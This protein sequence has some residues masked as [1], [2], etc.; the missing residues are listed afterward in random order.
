MS[1]R[2]TVGALIEAHLKASRNASAGTTN[3]AASMLRYLAASTPKAP[4]DGVL[5][6]AMAVVKARQALERIRDWGAGVQPDER[7]T[8]RTVA[9]DALAEIAALE[10]PESAQP[11]GD[12][13]QLKAPPLALAEE[14]KRL[15]RDLFNLTDEAEDMAH[16]SRAID[17]LAALA[18]SLPPQVEPAEMTERDQL[19][20]ARWHSKLGE[21]ADAY[22]ETGRTHPAR[23]K[24]RADLMMHALDCATGWR[25]RSFLAAQR[26]QVEPQ[27]PAEAAAFFLEWAD[28]WSEFRSADDMPNK[29]DDQPH[30]VTPL[31]GAAVHTK[32]S[33]PP[34]GQP[35]T[36]WPPGMLQDDSRELSRALA[37]K[38]DARMHAREAAESARTEYRMLVQLPDGTYVR[39]TRAELK[40]DDMVVFDGPDAFAD[41]DAAGAKLN[42]EID[43]AGGLD[44]WRA[45]RLKAAP[46]A[47]QGEPTPTAPP[48]MALVPLRLTREMDRVMQE[49]DWQWS[50][51]LAAAGTVTEEDCEIAAQ[52][53]QGESAGADALDAARCRRERDKSERRAIAFGDIVAQHVMAMR[54]AV[55]A[56]QREGADAGM[57]WI[58]NTLRGPGHLPNDEDIAFGAQALFDREMAEHDAFRAAHPGPSFAPPGSVQAAGED[59]LPLAEYHEDHGCAVWWTWQDGEWLGEPA[60]I[61]SPNCDDW[62]GYHTH[63]T[64]HPGFP[65]PLAD[66]K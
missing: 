33:A 9:A 40:G 27:A 12:S 66:H 13:G 58:A 6:L 37:G 26:P 59:A 7:H 38:P 16:L 2:L 46:E 21:L 35:L 28:G 32:A 34:Q 44:A 15:A 36:G 54:A 42:A 48:G 52:A 41:I 22:Y 18:A 51:L 56:W 55:V 20:L 1:D 19:D 14:V 50:D 49:E 64:P 10:A 11:S 8:Q 63:W 39:K 30:K 4:E 53:M 5:R 61:G 65:A 25:A 45:S 23:R 3:W 62:P 31:Y 47:V 57:T 17:R 24:A 29:W 60:Y 43:A